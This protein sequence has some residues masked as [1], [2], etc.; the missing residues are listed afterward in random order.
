MHITSKFWV[1]STSVHKKDIYHTPWNT[2]ISKTGK[3]KA[4]NEKQ[5]REGQ[6]IKILKA[7]CSSHSTLKA[8]KWLSGMTEISIN[9]TL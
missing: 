3:K 1:K 9:E 5:K 4:E 8:E 7:L 2:L 6:L